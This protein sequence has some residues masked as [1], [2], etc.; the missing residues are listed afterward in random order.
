MNP[1]EVSKMKLNNH[2]N[3]DILDSTLRDG[4]QGEGI[5]FSVNDKLNIVKA[6]DDFGIDFIEA[7]NP[8]SNPKDLDFFKQAANLQLKNALL[9][10][11][12]ST[13]RSSVKPCDD[14]NIQS[15]LAANVPVAVIFG[16]SWDMHVEEILKTSKAENLNMVRESIKY[17]K[18]KGL[19]VFFDA[20]HFFD[21]YASDKGYAF[22]VLK[23]AALGGADAL[24][25][26]DTNGG[27]L[28]SDV[29]EI[30]KKAVEMFPDKQIAIHC[31]NDTGCAVA[32]SIMAVRAGASQVQGTFIGVGERCGNADLSIII[33]NLRLK[34]GLEC[35]GELPKLF[36]TSR[37]IAEISNVSI[38]NNKPYVGSSAFSHKGGMHIDAVLK[39][40]K[41]FEHI[42]PES[43]GNVR[44]FLISEVSGGSAVLTKIKQFAP[45]LT[46]SSPITAKVLEKLKELEHYGYHFEAADASFELLVKRIIGT[47]EPHY[48]IVF[49]RTMG[50]FPILEGGMPAS[51]TV[52]V[53][54]GGKEEITAATGNGPVNALDLALRKALT[55]F[56][57]SIADIKLSDYKVRVLEQNSTTDARVRVLIE[58]TDSRRTWTT[59][60][61]SNDILEASLIAL[62]DAIE[63]KLSHL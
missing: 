41:S 34:C 18:S 19:S 31:H 24:A 54:V 62:S 53:E 17:L 55:V 61:V 1:K 35:N 38:E 56:Y 26:C 16:K 23:A 50:E 63:Y 48:R 13:C 2:R 59:I 5:S 51:A 7:G 43:V 11:F 28:P 60:G 46:K 27:A 21:G 3:I 40:Q 36:E 57:P 12:G 30:T 58:S 14:S 52:K 45:N 29:E 4:A 47:Y 10:A 44:K 6:L 22:E 8:G 15:I 25:L 39:L 49:Y 37:Q 9:C 20:E 33:P 42:E 32:N